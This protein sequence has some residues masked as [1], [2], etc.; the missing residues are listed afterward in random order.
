MDRNDQ[1]HAPIQHRDGHSAHRL[2]RGRLYDVLRLKC[3]QRVHILADGAA[4]VG[5]GLFS[6]GAGAAG[7]A[8]QLVVR[9]QTLLPRV[10]HDVAQKAAATIPNFVFISVS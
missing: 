9:Q 6:R 2:H 1:I 10:S 8:H 3:Q 4:D 7:H 5:G